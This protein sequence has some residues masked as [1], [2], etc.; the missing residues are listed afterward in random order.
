MNGCL[1]QMGSVMTSMIAAEEDMCIVAGVD[2]AKGTRDY[3][4][5]ANLFDVEEDADVIVDFSIAAMTPTL[6][7]YASTRQIPLLIGTTGLTDADRALFQK[8]ADRIP[9]F[10]A[11][12]MSVGINLMTELVNT[13]AGV[14]GDAFDIE[15][16]EKHH[17][18]KADAPSG[19]ALTL[20]SSIEEAFSVPAE[21]V[22]GRH[23]K[24]C[25]R[26]KGEIGIHAVRGGTIVGDHDVIYAGQDE[27]L[28]ISHSARSKQIFGSGALRAIR[29][30]AAA[31]PGIYTM[32]SI[33]NSRA[34][35]SIYIQEDQAII[36]I[37]GLPL[38]ASA[39]ADVFDALAGEHVNIDMISQTAPVAGTFSISFTLD[40]SVL[41]EA[42][43][44]IRPLKDKYPGFTHSVLAEITKI[45]VEGEGMRHQS[46]VAAKIFRRMADDGIIIRAMTTSETKISYIVD[47]QYAEQ[48]VES[49]K[50][51]FG[52]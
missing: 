34:L 33:I 25:R 2:K 5:Y 45:S 24:D 40:H 7:A 23:S 17:N 51:E 1:G 19:T 10:S 41:T 11:A 28:T 46:G 32:K 3:P 38:E 16:I 26:V 48:A 6:L 29:F 36:T 52:I 8:Y 21:H 14:L 31:E 13:A 9:I 47:R 4:I 49:I 18:K 15:I 42:I 12:N 50:Q 35:T 27:I 43:S 44:A 37:K 39:L 20:L 22:F 30:L